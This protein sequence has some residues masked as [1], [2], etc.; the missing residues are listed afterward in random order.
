MSFPLTV[1]LDYCPGRKYAQRVGSCVQTQKPGADTQS[2]PSPGSSEAD[3]C[4]GKFFSSEAW[5]FS[6]N[7]SNHGLPSCPKTLAPSPRHEPCPLLHPLPS[8]RPDPVTPLRTPP[9]HPKLQSLQEIK[10]PASGDLE[11]ALDMELNFCLTIQK[12]LDFAS[13]STPGSS[14]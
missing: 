11:P 12:S 14:P 10:G 5:E 2:R 3:M 8:T 6:L 13:Q 7:F 9:P 1:L 4:L